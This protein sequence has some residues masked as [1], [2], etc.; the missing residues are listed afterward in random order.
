MD[1][2]KTEECFICIVEAKKAEK[3]GLGRWM[4]GL[5]KNRGQVAAVSVLHLIT[6]PARRVFGWHNKAEQAYRRGESMA[7]E[8]RHSA[9]KKTY[10]N[11]CNIFQEV[12]CCDWSHWQKQK[13]DD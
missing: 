8:E 12:Y 9:N 4:H 6:G 3:R 13:S 5:S 11:K 2:E 1:V 7:G 10:E